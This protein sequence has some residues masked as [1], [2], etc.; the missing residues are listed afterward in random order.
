MERKKSRVGRA[1][2]G[3]SRPLGND[4]KAH[5]ERKK[6]DV[7][8]AEKCKFPVLHFHDGAILHT[9]SLLPIRTRRQCA[10]RDYDRKAHPPQPMTARAPSEC[11]W[12]CCCRQT[13]ALGFGMLTIS[14]H[15][16]TL[17][18]TVTARARGTTNEKNLITHVL[19]KTL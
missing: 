7:D 19:L 2:L 8:G 16:L 9:A 10:F 17:S 13:D 5:K 6:E 18:V 12:Y 3:E 1:L 14:T 11:L 4:S 15:I